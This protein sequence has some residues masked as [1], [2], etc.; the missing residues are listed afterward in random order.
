LPLLYISFSF[1]SNNI[2]T[3]LLLSFI[4]SSFLWCHAPEC[5]THHNTYI[6]NIC[7]SLRQRNTCI[8]FQSRRTSPPP[9]FEITNEVNALLEIIKF[10]IR[11]G[12]VVA[13]T[14]RISVVCRPLTKNSL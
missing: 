4:Q 1:A 5:I 3:F 14:A 9:I 13:Q 6:N 11:G 12:N 7:S 2:Y 8:W 10:L